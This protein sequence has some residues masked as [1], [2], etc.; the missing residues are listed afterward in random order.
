MGTEIGQ[1]VP[2]LEPT[3]VKD[4]LRVQA[5]DTEG[6]WF[7]VIQSGATET[8]K[9]LTLKDGDTEWPYERIFDKGLLEGC[10][11]VALIDPYLA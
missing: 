2:T 4:F 3:V 6:D 1:P 11:R 5:G 9:R 10:S 8:L 7:G